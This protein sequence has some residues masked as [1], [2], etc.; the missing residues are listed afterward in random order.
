MKML[1]F[2]RPATFTLAAVSLFV[3]TASATAKDRT[4]TSKG[5]HDCGVGGTGQV[6]DGRRRHKA[7]DRGDLLVQRL[8]QAEVEDLGGPVRGNLDIGRLEVAVN[9]TLGVRCLDG[10]GDLAGDRRRRLKWKASSGVRFWTR[11][12]IHGAWTAP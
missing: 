6:D 12:P 3:A 8:G 1:Q 9:D 7:A 2:S 11:I 5:G 10:L 4:W